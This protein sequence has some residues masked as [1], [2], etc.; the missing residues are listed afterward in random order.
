[1]GS[2]ADGTSTVLR[3]QLSGDG[4][5]TLNFTDS[6]LESSKVLR[7]VLD[8]IHGVGIPFITTD[9]ARGKALVSWLK[10]Y[11]CPVAIDTCRSLIRT[12]LLDPCADHSDSLF[13]LCA[14]LDDPIG[15]RQAILIAGPEYWIAEREGPDG[16][17]IGRN[18]ADATLADKV[19]HASCIDPS[20]MTREQLDDIPR[21]YLYALIRGLAVRGPPG[22]KGDEGD[23][24][25]VANE[26]YRVVTR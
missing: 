6:E 10:K 13:R 1:M 3:D 23:W 4:A 20:A 18:R 25:A 19:I 21:K 16:G 17:F 8:C 12:A 9:Y 22:G 26:F 15:C 7:D 14:Q 2:S 11:D 5:I 24:E